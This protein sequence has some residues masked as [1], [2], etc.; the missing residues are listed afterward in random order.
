MGHGAQLT[1][2]YTARLFLLTA[3]CYVDDMDLLHLSPS[4]HTTD[5]ELFA[6]VQA[7]TTDWGQLAQ[8]SDGA[9]KPEKCYVYFISYRFI[10][11][12]ARLQEPKH[13]LKESIMNP[14]THGPTS[15]N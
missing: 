8:A 10:N 14:S 5:R 13:L 6:Q 2:T 4:V 3:V 1:S 11:G 12:K 7:A 9:L 15:S